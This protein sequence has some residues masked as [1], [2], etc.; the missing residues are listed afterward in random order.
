M[1]F[2]FVS[3]SP[4]R[5]LTHFQQQQT[6][7]KKPRDGTLGLTLPLLRRQ[8]PHHLGRHRPRERLH[9]Q[10]AP[11]LLGQRDPAR[12]PAKGE[13]AAAAP[14]R[15][16]CRRGRARGYLRGRVRRPGPRLLAQWGLAGQR[17]QPAAGPL[18]LRGGVRRESS[19]GSRRSRGRRRQLVGR[20][21]FRGGGA[22]APCSWL[23]RF[24]GAAGVEARD[25]PDSSEGAAAAPPG[26]RR[27][28]SGRRRARAEALRL[29]GARGDAAMSC[30]SGFFFS[31]FLFLFFF[32]TAP[33]RYLSPNSDKKETR[34]EMPAR[35]LPLPTSVLLLEKNT[36]QEEE[37]R[38]KKTPRRLSL[39][40]SLFPLRLFSYSTFR[41][42]STPSPTIPE[43]A[44]TSSAAP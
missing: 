31:F 24:D 21:E 26:L 28:L 37:N 10:G 38:K 22:A 40:V 6:N 36:I 8:V 18:P 16:A 7:K 23:R 30:F 1:F 13:P 25:V 41:N 27:A 32:P 15:G 11:L 29:P 2:H 12:A 19:A 43:A 42:A 33:L 39:S 20:G 9:L 34:T 14:Q 3:F 35:H 4:R 44:T 5:P 17:L